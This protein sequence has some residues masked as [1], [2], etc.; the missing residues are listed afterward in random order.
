MHGNA[1]ELV[2]DWY[3]DYAAGAQTDPT[4]PKAGTYRVA[5]GGGWGGDLSYCRSAQRNG[6]LPTD[7][8]NALGFR[9]ARSY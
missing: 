1:W 5:R 9:L 6:S 4:G 8:G 7:T 2:E 3:G